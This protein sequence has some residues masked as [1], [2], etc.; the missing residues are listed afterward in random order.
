VF[1]DGTS[2]ELR[3]LRT[4]L[5]LYCKATVTELN[6]TKSRMLSNCISMDISNQIK[7]IVPITCIEFE[8]GFK[9][10]GFYLKPNKYHFEDWL[11]LY[12]KINQ[13]C[14]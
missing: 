8:Q 10:L 6:L 4:I 11:W 9:Y 3:S 13:S 14:A 1:R 12:K 2:Q 7:D 5:D